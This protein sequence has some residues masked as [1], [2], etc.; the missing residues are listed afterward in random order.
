MRPSPEIARTSPAR[1]I[2]RIS[3]SGS[4]ST[5]ALAS[6]GGRVVARSTSAW[7]ASVVR[8]SSGHE[9]VEEDADDADG[10]RG[11]GG[12]EDELERSPAE[13]SAAAG[14]ADEGAA[15]TPCGSWHATIETPSTSAARRTRE[16]SE[17]AETR[18]SKGLAPRTA[19]AFIFASRLERR[20]IPR[21]FEKEITLR[22]ARSS[23]LRVAL[24]LET[25]D[26]PCQILGSPIASIRFA[27]SGRRRTRRRGLR[28]ENRGG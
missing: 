6:P 3:S 2:C 17:C 10:E 4:R 19:F 1:P 13:A 12:T 8:G 21:L 26:R 20:R 15:G 11:K 9:V 16:R 7:S 14:M 18:L 24:P 5:L 27:R 25:A 23:S 28:A 22:R